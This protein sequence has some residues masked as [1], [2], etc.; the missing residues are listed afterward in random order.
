MVHVETGYISNRE[1]DDYL[2]SEKGQQ[3][4]ATC[5]TQALK[6][7]MVWLEK[8][9]LQTQSGAVLLND[10]EASAHAFLKQVDADEQKR[11]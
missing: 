5:I 7:Y 3:E 8:N 2:N 4:L 6:S 9:Q 10:K 11:K 1:E